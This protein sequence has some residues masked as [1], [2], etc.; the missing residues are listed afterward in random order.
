MNVKSFLRELIK[1]G[2]GQ[3]M[4]GIKV[5]NIDNSAPTY[6]ATADGYAQF[7]CR[8]NG[9][10]DWWVVRTP[11]NNL[12]GG[13]AAPGASHQQ[14]PW[15]PVKKGAT[16]SFGTSEGVPVTSKL[17][18]YS[19]GRGGGKVPPLHFYEGGS[20]CVRASSKP[21]GKL[22]RVGPSLRATALRFQAAC[23]T[24]GG[25]LT[26]LPKTD[27]FTSTCR[28]LKAHSSRSA[29]LSALRARST[30][31]R[32]EASSPFAREKQFNTPFISLKTA[33]SHSFPQKQASN[34]SFMEVAA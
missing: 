16:I 7:S 3:A 14:A 8:A 1:A 17:F 18:I 5:V 23:R 19:V 30:Q 4:P 11:E 6:V 33:L 34:N 32:R 13:F 21:S 29:A 2:S 28:W 26:P 22:Q 12:E 15:I 20:L 31:S 27:T 9:V 25:I 24:S 10:N